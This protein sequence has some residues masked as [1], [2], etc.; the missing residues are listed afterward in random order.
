[1]CPDIFWDH[2]RMNLFCQNC[3]G[4]VLVTGES[5]VLKIMCI[6]L[7][8]RWH[9]FD[10]AELFLPIGY[11]QDIIGGYRYDIFALDHTYETTLIR[12]HQ[13]QNGT[14]SFFNAFFLPKIAIVYICSKKVLTNKI[15]MSNILFLETLKHK[16]RPFKLVQHLLYN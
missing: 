16:E 3:E 1:M 11:I 7:P 6:S 9:H 15:K 12:T 5:H 10:A 13:A 4:H 14:F 2:I 8:L